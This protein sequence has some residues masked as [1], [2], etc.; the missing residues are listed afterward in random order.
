MPDRPLLAGFH[1]APARDGDWAPIEAGDGYSRCR[2]TEKHVRCP[3]RAV[4]T[5]FRPIG[6]SGRRAGWAYCADHMYG[7]WIEGGFVWQWRVVADELA[8]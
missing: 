5:L 7:R 6:S 3:A 1:F 2:S 8:S 4:A